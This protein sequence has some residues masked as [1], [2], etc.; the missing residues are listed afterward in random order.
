MQ[1]KALRVPPSTTTPA[2]TAMAT[3][4]KLTGESIEKSLDDYGV[5]AYNENSLIVDLGS[6]LFEMQVE[7]NNASS[8]RSCD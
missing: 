7:V 5:L 8:Y 3:V 1:V 6:K 2:I 4:V